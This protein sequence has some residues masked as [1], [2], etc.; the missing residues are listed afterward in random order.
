MTGREVPVA[1]VVVAS[2]NRAA[3]LDRLLRGLDAQDMTEPFEVIVVDDASTDRTPKVLD[4]WLGRENRFR[5]QALRQDPNRGPAAA[6]NRGWQVA[7]GE[8]ICFTDDDCIP[9]PAWVATHVAAV[10]GGASIVQGR[11]LPVPDQRD[12]WT[13]F[14]RSITRT[15]DGGFYETCNMAY[16]RDVVEQAG[17]FDE[18]FRF[19]YGEDTDLAWRAIGAG[20][21]ITFASEALVHHE[22]WPFEWHAFL[23]DL[24]RRE[25]TVMLVQKHPHL[26]QLFPAPWCEHRRHTGAMLTVGALGS[27]ARHPRK[28]SRW[29][30]VAGAVGHYYSVS[31]LARHGPRR[32]RYWPAYLPLLLAADLAEVGVMAAAS[33][34]H[35]TLLL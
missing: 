34:K 17:G 29:L 19:P 33:A 9:D 10:R 23:A 27:L 30:A 15:R 22:V 3:L 13:P 8:V 1:S 26:R 25:G 11:T 32:R 31:K 16:R 7:A 24:R 18:D 21:G 6:R 12:R 5:L 35:R 28:P 4:E 20:H 14:S 2:R